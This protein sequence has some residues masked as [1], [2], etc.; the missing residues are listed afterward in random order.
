MWSL[1]SLRRRTRG[2]DG[3]VAN[4]NE[5]SLTL[6]GFKADR[7]APVVIE[8]AETFVSVTFQ[9]MARRYR[10]GRL[11][12]AEDVERFGPLCRCQHADRVDRCGYAGDYVD[13]QLESLAYLLSLRAIETC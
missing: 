9:Q 12:D 5:A 10:F 6:V 1:S 2:Y 4:D 13:D 7:A 8:V 11:T 3:V